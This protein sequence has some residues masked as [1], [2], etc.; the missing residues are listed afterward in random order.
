[1]AK[2]KSFNLTDLD[3]MTCLIDEIFSE[4]NLGLIVYQLEDPAAASSLKLV[5]A[6]KQASRYTGSD[7]SQSV[8][9]YLPEAFPALAQTDVPE[10]YAEVVRTKQPR[11]VGAFEYSDVNVEKAYYAVK[12]FPMPNACVGIL[13][14]NITLRKQLE[15][16]VKH[17]AEQ[18]HPPEAPEAT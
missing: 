18:E 12:A 11:T 7:L 5:Y 3:T 1:M 6:N 17:R 10:L 15:E 13:F 2:P 16:M 14:E 4:M 9:K 8:G